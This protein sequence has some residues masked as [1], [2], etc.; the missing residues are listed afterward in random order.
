MLKKLLRRM[1]LCRLWLARLVG[2]GSRKQKGGWESEVHVPTDHQ[3]QQDIPCI[4]GPRKCSQLLC[5]FLGIL[6][7]SSSLHG[8][9]PPLFN[10]AIST[11]ANTIMDSTFWLQ[12]RS[13]YCIAKHFAVQL[14]VLQSKCCHCLPCT[15]LVTPFLIIQTAALSIHRDIQKQNYTSHPKLPVW[16]WAKQSLW[17]TLLIE[18]NLKVTIQTHF[19]S[20]ALL[21]LHKS[22]L[23]IGY[24]DWM[25][26]RIIM[27]PP[28][29]RIWKIFE[30]HH[31]SFQSRNMVL[32]LHTLYHIML[33]LITNC[34]QNF[35]FEYICLLS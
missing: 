34:L 21:A 25:T 8:F 20:N 33:S 7:L 5:P 26:L 1:S 22:V 14:A 35:S 24:P 6:K 32:H 28:S 27:E 23:R 31:S 12:G 10:G 29:A 15:H 9:R 17:K 18:A 30:C 16:T 19:T 3:G 2:S 4:G 13:R 11:G